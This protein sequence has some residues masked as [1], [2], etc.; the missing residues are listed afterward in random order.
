[1]L[2]SEDDADGGSAFGFDLASDIVELVVLTSDAA[3]LQTLREALG[4]TRRLWHAPS[5]EKVGDLLV[6]GE[7]GILVL[8]AQALQNP[9]GGVIAYIKNQF[10]DLVVVLAGDRDVENSVASLISDGTIYRFIHKPMSPGRAK[11]FIEAAVKRHADQR[12]RRAIAPAVA[13]S[14]PIPRGFLIAGVL[15]VFAV[16]IGA[17]LAL[18]AQSQRNAP[19]PAE[20]GATA[21]TMASP[22]LQ[23]AVSALAANRLTEPSGN[24]ALELYLRELARDPASS[25]A[26]AGLAEI[27]ERLYARAQ[28]ALLEERLDQAAA[29]IETARKSGVESG[30]VALLTAELAKSREEARTR[31]HAAAAKIEPA[32]GAEI[33]RAAAGA[34][35]APAEPA[36]PAAAPSATAES[37]PAASQPEAAPTAEPAPAK[38]TPSTETA[39]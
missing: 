34:A 13:A 37:A 15:G 17:A 6:A 20:L 21:S 12:R 32:P 14:S 7:V 25:A 31:R 24:N 11:L 27:R 1:M 36:T 2:A 3:F 28:D 19:L 10:P 5:S 22:L 39:S 26:R 38:V 29:A 18:R 16:C 30:R 8:D 35:I 9:A 23:Q 33:T 4:G